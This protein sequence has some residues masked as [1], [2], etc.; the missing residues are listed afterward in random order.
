MSNAK[1]R[2]RIEPAHAPPRISTDVSGSRPAPTWPGPASMHGAQV[3]RP[4]LARGRTLEGAGQLDAD[5]AP[6]GQRLTLALSLAAAMAAGI[7]LFQAV[8]VA[9]PATWLGHTRAETIEEQPAAAQSRRQAVFLI[10]STL[11]AL[12]DAN[13]SGNY[14]VLRDLA[15]PRFQER[16]G[17][18]RLRDTFAAFRQ[19]GVDLS[20][21]GMIAPEVTLTTT[22]PG[23]GV[24]ELHGHLPTAEVVPEPAASG[25]RVR[26]AMEF[27]PVQGH[28]RLLTLS[29]GVDAPR[30]PR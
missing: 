30:G 13:R 2:T 11:M 17:L 4:S 12:N 26:F 3:G 22:R 19:A 27:E 28:W 24:L 9:G 16:N 1:T 21:A 29:I 23:D 6:P 14:S 10:R 20:H 15:G 7:V 25:Q 5:R 18:P 8:S